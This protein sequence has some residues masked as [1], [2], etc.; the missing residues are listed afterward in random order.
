MAKSIRSKQK[1]KNRAVLRKE[2]YAPKQKERQEACTKRQLVSVYLNGNADSFAKLAD[3]LQSSE[4]VVEKPSE[5]IDM[6]EN[7]SEKPNKPFAFI[8]RTWENPIPDDKEVNAAL[9][10]QKELR[11]K[12][13][14]AS[15]ERI[16][17]FK[18]QQA[19]RKQKAKEEKLEKEKRKK[20]KQY[21]HLH[22]TITPASSNSTMDVEQ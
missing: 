13:K 8:E 12:E 5:D 6:E 21:A 7:K 2:I 10:V 22:K 16:A 1:K 14:V 20:Q 3:V 9:A 18:Q 4:P 15:E 11:D 19:E 17:A